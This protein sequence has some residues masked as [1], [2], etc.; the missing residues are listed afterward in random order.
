[1]CKRYNEGTL[2][3][4]IKRDSPLETSNQLHLL[5]LKLRYIINLSASRALMQHRWLRY[6]NMI[7]KKHDS[8][9][10]SLLEGCIKVN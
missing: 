8:I 2:T 10:I 1:M 6:I 5:K 3:C 9:R 4:F 7:H